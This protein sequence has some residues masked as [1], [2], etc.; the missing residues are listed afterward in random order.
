MLEGGPGNRLWCRV[1]VNV[2][3]MDEATSDSEV[4]ETPQP[5]GTHVLSLALNQIPPELPLSLSSHLLSSVWK[6]KRIETIKVGV[7]PVLA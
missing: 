6:K 1:A 2:G 7:W 4:V 5:V 3:V